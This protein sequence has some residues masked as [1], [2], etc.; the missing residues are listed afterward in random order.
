MGKKR[1]T[2][3]DIDIV[4]EEEKGE[5]GKKAEEGHAEEGVKEPVSKKKLIIII[6]SVVAAA[7]IITVVIFFTSKKPEKKEESVKKLP[8]VEVPSVP[9][10]NLEP[11][12]IP[13]ANKESEGRFLRVSI[14]V[15]LSDKDIIREFERNVVFLREN[16]FFILKN[17]EL[18][19]YHIR[20]KHGT[21]V[22]DSNQS[23][24]Y[25]IL[26]HVT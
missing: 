5:E 25:R 24:F 13:L 12:L 2:E 3:L 11:F 15:E 14:S 18:K 17:K 8:P 4:P 1:K 10:Y 16:I 22:R 26:N 6:S 19:G 21:P 20:F 23:V 9:V 7:L